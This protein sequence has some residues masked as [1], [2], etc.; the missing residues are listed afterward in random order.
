MIECEVKCQWVIV[1]QHTEY[2]LIIVFSYNGDIS[3]IIFNGIK[4]THVIVNLEKSLV[5]S[6]VSTHTDYK[7]GPSSISAVAE[8]VS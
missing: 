6:V 3:Y 2:G 7:W 8:L 5:F 1:I 4:F